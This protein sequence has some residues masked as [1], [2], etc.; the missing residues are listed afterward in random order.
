M[1]PSGRLVL[2]TGE[3]AATQATIAHGLARA[4]PRAVHIDG[5]VI[6][7]LVVSGAAPPGPPLTRDGLEQ[8]Y[9]RWSAAIAV[10]ET[11]QQAGFDA[12]ISDT[13]LGELFAD[14]VDFVSPAPLHVVALGAAGPALA[15][16]PRVG[17]WL[18]TA[19]VSPEVTVTEILARLDEAR[20]DTSE[21]TEPA[22]PTE[23]AEPTEPHQPDHSG[24]PGRST[25]QS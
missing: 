23:P 17:L 5:D 6:A 10:A 12:I 18:R 11:Y 20:I 25:D 19:G 24:R 9:L 14:F 7:G 16:T 4:L 3:R 15:R 21:P 13:V 2:V 22:G 1:T 8:L